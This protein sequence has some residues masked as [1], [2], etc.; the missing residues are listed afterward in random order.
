M[1]KLISTVLTI[2]MVYLMIPGVAASENTLAANQNSDYI[3]EPEPTLSHEEIVAFLENSPNTQQ[4]SEY[5]VILQEKNRA[6]NILASNS[7]TPSEQVNAKI[8][9]SFDPAK[10][11][12]QLQKKTDQELQ[13]MGFS[14]ERIHLIRNFRGTDAE[15]QA[16]GATCSVGGNPKYTKNA[17]GCWSKVTFAFSWSDIP[18]W[19]GTDALVARSSTS[20]YSRVPDVKCT[21]NYLTGTGT[22]QHIIN[23]EYDASHLSS[24]PWSD[25]NIAGFPFKFRIEDVA[26][27]YRGTFYALSGMAT[28]VFVSNNPDV[29]LSYA[30]A[31]RKLDFDGSIGINFST[32]GVT[33]ALDFGLNGM[34]YVLLPNGGRAF[35]P[36]HFL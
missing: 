12:Y 28:I 2:I 25:G 22:G 5:D 4:S 21:I 19:Q 32:A 10:K 6:K 33:G 36:Y 23:K 26:G 29:R 20:Y 8:I 15:M 31:Q 3:F 1:K 7:A 16:L 11:V 27:I 13:G 35:D 30:Y 24:N 17:S 14:T 34:T 18:I 9:L